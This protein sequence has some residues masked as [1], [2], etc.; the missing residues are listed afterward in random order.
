MIRTATEEQTAKA[1]RREGMQTNEYCLPSRLRGSNSSESPP[2]VRCAFVV[3]SL[4]LLRREHVPQILLHVQDSLFHAAFP[5]VAEPLIVFCFAVGVEDA[6]A[7]RDDRALPVP[8][9]RSGHLGG[10]A[11][12]A[13]TWEQKDG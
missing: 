12:R 5:V 9:S 3:N 11:L 2:I 6:P 1:R 7:G 13:V 4:S 8:E 10:R